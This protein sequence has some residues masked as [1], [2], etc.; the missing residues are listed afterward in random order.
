MRLTGKPN[1]I[2]EAAGPANC[3]FTAEDI[4]HIDV[5][6][7]YC[8]TGLLDRHIIKPMKKADKKKKTYTEGQVGVLLEEIRSQQ[9]AI[10]EGQDIIKKDT[11]E[12][13]AILDEHTG[14]IDLLE[15]RMLRM[16]KMVGLN[17]DDIAAIKEDIR[18]I[19]EDFSKR[20]SALEAK[21]T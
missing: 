14:K 10:F 8:L 11:K 7:K 1:E 13:K 3:N 15:M 19:R 9:K 5:E 20:V 16:E 2:G 4:L 21:L 17:T 6:T 12:I 18:L